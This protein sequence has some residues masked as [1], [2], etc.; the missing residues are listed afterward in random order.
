MMFWIHLT[1]QTHHWQII[2]NLLTDVV[3][4][5]LTLKLQ[6]ALPL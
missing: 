2:K 1:T 3:Y 5:N 4:F 6:I